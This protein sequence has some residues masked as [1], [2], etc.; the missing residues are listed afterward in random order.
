MSVGHLTRWGHYSEKPH[1]WGCDDPVIIVRKCANCLTAIYCGKEC[2]TSDWKSEKGGHKARC[3]QIIAQKA[4]TEAGRKYFEEHK[5]EYPEKIDGLVKNL[6]QQSPE[7]R[8]AFTKKLMDELI[9]FN[10][11]FE[12]SILYP[13]YND[14]QMTDTDPNL[15]P[16]KTNLVCPIF[17]YCHN[18]IGIIDVHDDHF[19]NIQSFHEA[20]D[21]Q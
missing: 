12:Q 14:Y 13:G 15:F 10:E 9:R 3:K 19:I 21:I 18:A 20:F 4:E 8:R 7:E 6:I 11:P 17:R 16:P 1:C 2:Q 5:H